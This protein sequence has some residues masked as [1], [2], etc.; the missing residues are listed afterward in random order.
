MTSAKEARLSGEGLIVVLNSWVFL[1]L[2]KFRESKFRV[3]REWHQIYFRLLNRS[4]F[5][6][7]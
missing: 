5:Y 6:S 4:G 3:L 7:L 1:F 2:T